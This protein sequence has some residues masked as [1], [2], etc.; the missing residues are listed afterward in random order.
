MVKNMFKVLKACRLIILKNQSKKLI[1]NGYSILKTVA[2]NILDPKST[3]QIL[4]N[5]QP[6]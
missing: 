6:S 1:I 2:G 5:Q 4:D 3:T